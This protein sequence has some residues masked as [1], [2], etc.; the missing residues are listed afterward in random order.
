MSEIQFA[1]TRL[2]YTTE[3]YAI[4]FS[5]AESDTNSAT[6]L[7]TASYRGV[8]DLVLEKEREVRGR[9]RMNLSAARKRTG[10]GGRRTY[11]RIGRNRFARNA[12]IA[13]T[14]DQMG[15][16]RNE[17]M[18]HTYSALCIRP[19]QQY[20]RTNVNVLYY[21]CVALYTTQCRNI[22]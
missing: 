8:I 18:E 4:I 22:G 2:N 17:E 9:N 16:F 7:K 12:F 3:F 1:V 11:G 15:N 13:K 19:L 10:R 14:D 5:A 6:R 21:E 20:K